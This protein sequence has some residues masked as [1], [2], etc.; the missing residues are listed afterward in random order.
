[1]AADPLGLAMVGMMLL[2]PKLVLRYPTARWVR[3]LRGEMRRKLLCRFRP[4]NLLLQLNAS[5]PDAIPAADRCADDDGLSSPS[6]IS[7]QQPPV[8]TR[9]RRLAQG[10]TSLPRP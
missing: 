9:H 2:I 3:L 5:S 10:P 7:D 4:S 1:M 8:P 6:C